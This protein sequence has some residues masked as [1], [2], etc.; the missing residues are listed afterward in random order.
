MRPAGQP[1][2]PRVCLG[3]A[4]LGDEGPVQLTPICTC[5]RK[6]KLPGPPVPLRCPRTPIPLGPVARPLPSSPRAE[7]GRCGA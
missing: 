7:E 1:G 2:M 5:Y 4:W 6:P 3:G